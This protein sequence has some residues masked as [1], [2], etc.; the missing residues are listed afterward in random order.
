MADTSGIHTTAFETDSFTLTRLEVVS[1]IGA[2]VVLGSLVLPWA[3]GFGNSVSGFAYTWLSPVFVV[4]AGLAI[5]LAVPSPYS[6]VRY[7][8]LTLVGVLHA[9]I[10]VI[11][12]LGMQ[13]GTK[14]IG[15]LVFTLGGL[16]VTSGGYG[17]L[18]REMSPY[19]ATA[20]VCAMS[21]IVLVAGIVGVQSL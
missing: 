8:L 17:S 11:L 9:S 1:V 13:A 4:G 2:A 15:V 5:G 19:R 16:L 18:I 20:L 7:T 12:L 3:S 10:G 14:G 6:R 21:L